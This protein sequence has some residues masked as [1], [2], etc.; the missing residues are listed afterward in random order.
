MG[1]IEVFGIIFVVS[2]LY[3]LFLETGP[4]RWLAE[5]RTWLSVV[6]GVGYVTLLMRLLGP[7][8]AWGDW[9]IAWLVS[10]APVIIRSLARE[11]AREREVW[12][13]VRR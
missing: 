12:R 5:E 2:T 7:A 6:I 3:A 13:E 11:V 4:G 10:G 9:L 1:R 8:P